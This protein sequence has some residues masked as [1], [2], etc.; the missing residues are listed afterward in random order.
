ML[1]VEL[2]TCSISPET[3]NCKALK[4]H[5]LFHLATAASSCEAEVSRMHADLETPLKHCG[6]YKTD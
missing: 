6:L 4:M 5:M 3:M 2:Q 1:I